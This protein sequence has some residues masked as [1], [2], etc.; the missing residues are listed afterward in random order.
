MYGNAEVTL[1]N[2]KLV[3]DFLPADIFVGDLSHHRA[4]TFIIRLRDVPSLPEGTV[5]FIVDEEGVSTQ[6]KVDIPNPD[7]DFTELEFKRLDY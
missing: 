2:D 3:V 7:F 6:M 1:E 4:D 5:E